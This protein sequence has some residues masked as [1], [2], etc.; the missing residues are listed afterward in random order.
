MIS[1]IK[2]KYLPLARAGFKYTTSRIMR[3][4]IPL[5][6][7]LFL[8]ER[9]NLKCTYCFP[10]SPG[11]KDVKE[12][13]YQE[14]CDV[15]DELYSLGT[16]YITLLGG[17]PLIRND[18]GKIV[19]YI[20]GKG[21]IVEAGTNGYFTKARIKDMKKLNLVCHSIDGIE[22]EHDKN[23]GKGSYQK[24]IESIRICTENKVPIQMRAVFTKNNVGSLEYLIDLAKKFNTSLGLA[25]QAIVKPQDRDTV[26]STAELRAFWKK[27]RDHKLRG[28]PLDK[29]VYLL[30]N[31]IKYPLEIPMEKIFRKGDPLP[32]DYNWMKCHLSDGYM[33]MDCNGFVYPCAV[34]FGKFGK[35]I[36][37]VGVKG[38]WDY[39][40][41]N[42]C[43]FCRQSMQD[44]KSYFFACDIN[45][46]MVAM[47]N[48]LSKLRQS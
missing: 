29:S 40:Q 11:R 4:R 33:F 43:V 20:A 35:S 25:E 39:L 41:E 38:A 32:R 3:K 34:L 7:G 13:S 9:C 27:V 47:K 26:M 46:I 42:D 2:R 45:A 23:R 1:K 21:I 10:N 17:E 44:L 22:E 37:D 8:T 36:H 16:R 48:F 15:V 28:D 12:F 18:F 30:D 31:I 5:Y 19:D 24:A 14:I 6:V